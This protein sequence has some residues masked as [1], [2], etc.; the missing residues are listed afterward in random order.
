MATPKKHFVKAK[1]VK[2]SVFE[3]YSSK[4]YRKTCKTCNEGYHSR[5]WQA[6][7]I[8]PGTALSAATIRDLVKDP[9]K[10]YY[11]ENCKKVTDWN[12]NEVPNLMGLP[13]LWDYIIADWAGKDK[14][15]RER[16]QL[17][18]KKKT[19]ISKILKNLTEDVPED[20]PIHNPT[21]YGH[22][23][24]DDEVAL[25]IKTEIWDKLAKKKKPHEVDPKSIKQELND[26]AGHFLK[27]LKE[28]GKRPKGIPGATK[29][30]WPKQHKN[31][32]N[33]SKT[34]F[35]PFS[36]AKNPSDPHD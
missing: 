7:H 22:V 28:R 15:D 31:R 20:L 27:E 34:W 5:M 9:D 13:T 19:Q 35:W 10:A 30:N 4:R 18:Q 21:N 11:I 33:Y 8:L 2:G 26:A 17:S 23:D 24:F 3:K 12:I 32:A 6:H 25:H 29:E 14:D 1:K 36:M 16:F